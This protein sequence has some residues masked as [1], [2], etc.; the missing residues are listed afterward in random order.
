M[1]VDFRGTRYVRTKYYGPVFPLPGYMYI[2][3]YITYRPMIMQIL[4]QVR[5]TTYICR[6]A[7]TGRL[8]CASAVL[9]VLHYA[10][11]Y[12]ST[13]CTAH[14]LRDTWYRVG[15]A[16]SRSGT[17]CT[18]AVSHDLAI[19]FCTKYFILRTWTKNCNKKYS[20]QKGPPER[21]VFVFI[22]A[23]ATGPFQT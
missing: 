12:C 4:P 7:C 15:I 21:I 17:Q 9:R 23:I 20:I 10:T 8:H 2:H 22:I 19:D 1:Q 5:N 3:N 14:I 6:A 11:A 16:L 13:K 18:C